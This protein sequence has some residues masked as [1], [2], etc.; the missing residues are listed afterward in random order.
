MPRN[1][2]QPIRGE[3]YKWESH[4]LQ[5]SL[6][7]HIVWINRRSCIVPAALSYKTS[8]NLVDGCGAPSCWYDTFSDY[9]EYQRTL[10]SKLENS[11][12]SGAP[13]QSWM[14]LRTFYFQNSRRRRQEVSTLLEKWINAIQNAQVTD[15]YFKCHK[16]RSYKSLQSGRL[17]ANICNVAIPSQTGRGLWFVTSIC[18]RMTIHVNTDVAFFDATLCMFY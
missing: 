7:L 12:G 18:V 1:L 5:T 17:S 4:I 13:D 16:G 10:M 8:L 11:T 6:C 2:S 14:S 3:L 9:Y 15:K